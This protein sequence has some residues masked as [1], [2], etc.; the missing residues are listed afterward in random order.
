MRSLVEEA[1]TVIDFDE[2]SQPGQLMNISNPADLSL[3]VL[4]IWAHFFKTNTQ[5]PFVNIIGRGLEM[6]R[7]ILVDHRKGMM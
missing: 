7:G 3:S 1:Y 4:S 6:Y 2:E 5:W